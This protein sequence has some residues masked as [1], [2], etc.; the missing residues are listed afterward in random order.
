[1]PSGS[2]NHDRRLGFERGL[3]AAITGV[4]LLLLAAVPSRLAWVLFGWG[5]T[6]PRLLRSAAGVVFDVSA[7]VLLFVP[8]ALALTLLPPWLSARWRRPGWQR[9]GAL[10]PALLAG[11]ALWLCT[12]ICQE[13][14]WER[15]AFPTA[16][17]L[18]GALNASFLSSLAGFAGYHRVLVPML[19]GLGLSAGWVFFR[20]RRPAEPVGWRP[21][22]LGLVAGTLVAAGALRGLAL[23]QESLSARTSSAAVGDPV[24]AVL[25]SAQDLLADRGQQTPR[26]LVAGA[27]LPPGLSPK[28]AA[29]L[30]WPAAGAGGEPCRPAHA[31]PL[32]LDQE[33]FVPDARGQKLRAALSAASTGLFAGQDR[34][35]AVFLLSLEGFRA[36]D[37]HALNPEAPREISPFVSGLYEKAAEGPAAGVLAAPRVYQAGVRTAQGVGALL[38]GLGTLPYNLSL[39]R[40]LQP[41]EVRCLPD[42]LHDAGFSGAFHYG[43]DASFDGM[44]DFFR[45]HGLAQIVDQ[46]VLPSTVAKGTWGAA[47]DFVVFDRAVEDAAKALEAGA[48]HFSFVMSL[49]NHGPFTAPEDLPAAVRERVDLALASVANRAGSDDRARLLTQSYTDAAVER[50]FEALQKAGLADRSLVVISADHSTGHA[51]VWGPNENDSD[52]AKARIPVLFVLPTARPGDPAGL[53]AN[54]RTAQALLDQGPLSQNDLPSLLLTLLAGHRS[55]RDLPAAARWHTL[56]GQVTSASFVAPR[57]SCVIGINGVSQFFALGCDGRRAGEYEES[58][59]L[60]TRSDRYRVTPTLIPITATLSEALGSPARCSLPSQGPKAAGSR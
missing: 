15:G 35:V 4:G 59:F 60:K 46:S 17:D 37:V 32:D 23:A 9:A 56:G 5:A 28:G 54:V 30:G 49:S 57:D 34:P 53:E 1:M 52:D 7:M 24:T 27:A 6:G 31:R 48:P 3:A 55:L 19:A 25:E 18:A 51:Y 20:L 11:A 22:A 58:V 12:E 39:I 42:V 10:L 33:P 45:A 16:F 50:F 36:D 44:A 21:W 43:S 40:D 13:V 38:C 14:K 47:T 2:F 26:E 29:L 8:F 41:F